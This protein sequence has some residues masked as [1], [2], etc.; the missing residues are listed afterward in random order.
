ANGSLLPGGSELLAVWT[1]GENEYA[2]LM[3]LQGGRLDAGGSVPQSDE[4]DALIPGRNLC[5]RRTQRQ[6]LQ[7]A[8]WYARPQYGAGT[9]ALA[10]EVSP[11]PEAA[12]LWRH[13]V[14]GSARGI[15]IVQL[16]RAGC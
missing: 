5:A 7:S 3:A 8:L 1:V 14:E 10:V 4:L 2:I 9:I 16:E 13:I 11:L 12:V 6:V 15:Q